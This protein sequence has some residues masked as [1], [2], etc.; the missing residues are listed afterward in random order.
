M[1]IHVSSSIGNTISFLGTSILMESTSLVSLRSKLCSCLQI[2]R[3]YDWLVNSYI[4]DF[5]IDNHWNKLPE[6]WRLHLEQLHPEE[7]A[8]LLNYNKFSKQ[9][10]AVWPLSLLAL[11]HL[12]LQLSIPR[13]QSTNSIDLSVSQRPVLSDRK[14]GHAFN[15]CVKPKKRHEIQLMASICEYSCQISPVDF[16]V[17]FGAGLGHL[18]RL[19]GYGYGVRVSCI[20]MRSELNLQARC[21][22][23]KLES[24]LQ[25]HLPSENLP[26]F[27]RPKHVTLCI[28]PD[29]Q[30]HQFLHII[31]ESQHKTNT[32]FKFGI[33]GLHPC[34]DLAVILM[35][36]FTNIP[37]ARFL[38]FASCCYMK[39]TTA[40]TQ[41][42]I[43]LQ[44]YPLSQYLLKQ[45]EFSFLS[46][47]ALEISCHGMEIYC[48]RL[49][50]GDYEYLKVHSFRA[51]A[52]R[53]IINQWPNLRHCGLRSVKHVPGMDFE[54]YFYKATQ[55]VEASN[56]P[57]S[58]LQTTTTQNDLLHWQRIVIFYTLRL[59]FAP[60]IES[61]ILYDRAL[62][63]QENECQV[64][65]KAAF[66]PRISPRNHITCSFKLK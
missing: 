16:V 65:I 23:T 17:D 52:E 41:S 20:E 4:L 50:R 45:Q 15:K 30:P 40:E 9:K 47:E 18:A 6:S 43:K 26:C 34:G 56:L 1:K 37:Q 21:I 13:N 54:D 55:G 7:L 19:L 25:K 35:R 3:L 64:N 2:L 8:T 53:I 44:G 49:A 11:R 31:A 10:H 29:M 14:L 24:V 42:N 59:M 38:N 57:R 60:L 27:K 39:L 48:D 12:L 36:M 5:Y 66:D 61:I 62:Y 32:N 28:T 63:L 46:Y 33:I 22:D 58:D 51:A